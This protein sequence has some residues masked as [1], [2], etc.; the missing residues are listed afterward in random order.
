ML[1]C[2]PQHSLPD[3]FVWMI[4]SG[5]RMAY[6]RVSARDLIYSPTEAES[7]VQCGRM[8]TVV[9]KLP[10]KQTNTPASW[11]V[12]AK[13]TLYLWL[14]VLGHKQHFYAGLPRGFDMSS[15]LRNAERVNALAPA[16][17]HY[18]DKHV[19]QL[20]AHIYQA[21]SLIG[22]DA[23]GLSDPFACVYI[24]EFCRQT[25]V[26]EETLSPTWDELLVFDDVLVYGAAE[27]IRRDPPTIVVEIYDRD[28]VGK[29]EFIGRTIGRPRV[30]LR[31]EAYIIPTLEW[32][33]IVRGP[34]GA[35]E[36]LA[37]FELL[38]VG[39]E[40]MPRLTEPKP[41]L[42][43]VQAEVKR[44]TRKELAETCAIL[45]VP[46]DVRPNLARF[47]VEVLFWGLRDLKR[48]HFMSVDKPRIDVECSGTILN[49][50]IIQNAK[51]NPNFANM[52]K[53]FDLELPVEENYA[54]P[55]T[56]RCVDC[57]SFGRYTLVGTHQ[58]TSI[59]KYMHRPQPRDEFRSP[60]MGRGA[61]IVLTSPVRE[62]EHA[63]AAAAAIS[64]A[65]G[66][67]GNGR[68][69]GKGRQSSCENLTFYGAACV[70]KRWVF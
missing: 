7:G 1:F 28:N 40:N 10:G 33:D 15:E 54:P 50:S 56:I 32:F 12:P 6:H 46:R 47:R 48:V 14:G 26:I 66:G 8:Q 53:F 63:A 65:T 49:S 16:N 62:Q 41:L 57:R 21:R 44:K 29:S 30:K 23:S 36:L 24:T 34:D 20:R 22:S 18:V 3:I 64:A 70:G 25:Q 9:M 55:I 17:I 13:L 19:F 31:D 61:Q 11:C 60:E 37:A 27:E 4:A 42:A 38:E 5:K 35:G 45:P 58:I 2:Q 69:P 39:A 67:N 43:S 68:M 51:R 52:V 59:H